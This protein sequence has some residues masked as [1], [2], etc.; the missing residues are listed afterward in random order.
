MRVVAL[1]SSNHF[2]AGFEPIAKTIITADTPGFT[3]HQIDRFE[4]TL[5]PHPLW[6][7][8]PN[9]PLTFFS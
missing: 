3:T 2:R 8:S 1:K 4:K 9:A 7:I 6:P 5:S